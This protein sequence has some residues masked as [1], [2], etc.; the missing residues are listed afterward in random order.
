MKKIAS[1]ILVIVFM[2]SM[3]SLASAGTLIKSG[4]SVGGDIGSTECTGELHYY[5]SS[6]PG[7]DYAYAETA[8]IKAGTKTAKITIYYGS[9]N[10]VKNA[11]ATGYADAVTAKAYPDEDYQAASATSKHTYN[12]AE[13]GT[14]NVTQTRGL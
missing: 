1:M 8:A 4:K 2:I 3:A 6:S 7:E 11:T 5:N 13:Y 10:T 12:S 9:S 14:W